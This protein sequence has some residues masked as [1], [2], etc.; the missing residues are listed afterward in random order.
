MLTEEEIKAL[1]DKNTAL[2]SQVSDLTTSTTS[3]QSKMEQLL[4]ETKTAKTAAKVAEEEKTA[5]I[6]EKALKDGNFEE[7][8]QVQVAANA[9][10]RADYDGLL[11]NIATKDRGSLAR[12]I[13][14]KI[15]EGAN[16]EILSD[17]ISSRLK[18][19][20]DGIKITDVNGGLTV[21]TAD[22]LANEFKANDRYASLINGNQ[23][24]GGG[25]PGGPNSG[26]AANKTMNRTEFDGLNPKAKMDFIKDGGQTTDE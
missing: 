4:T 5:A 6:A 11:E 16:A 14:G 21:L 8:H 20:D 10:L 22:D 2:E 9:S 18:S 12:S 15:A 24:G 19:T 23:S 17:Y 3:M 1:Q 26:G 7:L 25:A 13:A